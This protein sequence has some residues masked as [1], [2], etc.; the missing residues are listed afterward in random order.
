MMCSKSLKNKYLPHFTLILQGRADKTFENPM[1]VL[2]AL[3]LP[4]LGLGQP[5]Q[6]T[7]VPQRDQLTNLFFLQG[8]FSAGC[9]DGQF[10][11]L[12]FTVFFARFFLLHVL[13][14]RHCP[15]LGQ[16][17]QES[18]VPTRDQLT[19]LSSDD[20]HDGILTNVTGRCD[21]PSCYITN[22]CPHAP[23]L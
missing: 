7:S 8:Y 20:N 15:V 21:T 11:D 12:F 13:M 3:G 1:E 19:Y 14:R 10:S 22:R 4:V 9:F 23:Q 16:P 18:S 2:G 17:E 5:E 6:G